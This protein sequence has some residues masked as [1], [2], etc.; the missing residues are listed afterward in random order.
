MTNPKPVKFELYFKEAKADARDR[1]GI[2][3]LEGRRIRPVAEMP[4]CSAQD[5]VR[6]F[7]TTGRA[8]AQMVEDKRASIVNANGSP[9]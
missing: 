1:V 3:V 8:V 9:V 5:I 4:L 2:R 7:E 6:V